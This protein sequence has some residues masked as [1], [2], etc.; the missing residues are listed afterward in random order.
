MTT[1]TLL[2]AVV[3]ELRARKG[4]LRKIAD[5]TGIGYSTV[6]N[7]AHGRTKNPSVNKIELLGRLFWGPNK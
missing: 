1:M 7:I 2:D 5:A 3:K 4:Q 6:H